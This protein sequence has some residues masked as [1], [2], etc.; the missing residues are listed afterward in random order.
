METQFL[1]RMGFFTKRMPLAIGGAVN[2]ITR[3][4]GDGGGLAFQYSLPQEEGGAEGQ[5]S[6]A[7]SF[8]GKKYNLSAAFSYNF[9]QALVAGDREYIG[10]I[11]SVF[12][13][14]PTRFDYDARLTPVPQPHES[15]GKDGLSQINPHTKYCEMDISP[16]MNVIPEIKQYSGF[17]SWSYQMP[18][19]WTLF[20]TALSSQK[21]VHSRLGPSPGIIYASDVPDFIFRFFEAG[22]RRTLQ[23]STFYDVRLGLKAS[24]NSD[25][26]WTHHMGISSFG[27]DLAG[28]NFLNARETSNLYDCRLGEDYGLE[29]GDCDSGNSF[30]PFEEKGQRGDLSSALRHPRYQENSSLLS[31]QSDVEGEMSLGSVPVEIN[32]GIQFRQEMYGVDAPQESYL[33][34]PRFDD[35]QKQRQVSSTFLGFGVM[36]FDSKLKVDFNI[37]WDR[38]DDFGSGFAPRVAFRTHLFPN[39]LLR[40]SLAR[41]F[42]APSLLYRYGPNSN[43]FASIVDKVACEEAKAQEKAKVQEKAKAQEKAGNKRVLANISHYCSSQIISTTVVSNKNLKIESAD[44]MNVGVFFNPKRNFYVGADWWYLERNNYI[45]PILSDATKLEYE[46][47]GRFSNSQ[48][49][50]FFERRLKWYFGGYRYYSYP[51]NYRKFSSK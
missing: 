17:V 29:E 45:G 48:G 50:I 2:I 33:M 34:A 18:N 40:G 36:P 7:K 14:Y 15:C 38:Y 39:V 20:T 37:R 44:T 5:V 13:D 49:D 51:D 25:W 30:D 11:M 42:Q 27:L 1:K 6:L 16:L 9:A 41:S 21:R 12:S 31:F 4:E 46:E 26:A 43:L 23:D 32:G 28:K 3:N 8:F 24:L 19:R 22:P 10:P 47:E 35:A